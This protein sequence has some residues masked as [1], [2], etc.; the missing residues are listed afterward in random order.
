MK[1]KL[2]INEASKI[3]DVSTYTLRYWEKVFSEFL[4]PPRTKGNQRRYDKKSIETAVEI[5]KLLKESCFNIKGARKI[6]K[7]RYNKTFIEN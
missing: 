6:L 5:K 2:T 4:S 7:K 3:I 1:R